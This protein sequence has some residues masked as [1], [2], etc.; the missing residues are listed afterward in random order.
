MSF[1]YQSFKSESSFGCRK[2]PPS[3]NNSLKQQL[4]KD[5]HPNQQSELMELIP[6]G[7]NAG[8]P[9]PRELV[10]L[11]AA[12]SII[13]CTSERAPRID[14]EVDVLVL[15]GGGAGMVAALSAHGQGASVLLATKLRLGDSNT[16][17]ANGISVA[18]GKKD[19]KSLHFLD[20]FIAGGF[21]AD[22]TLVRTLVEE[23]PDAIE[24]LRMQGV[25]LEWNKEASVEENNR[26]AGHSVARGVKSLIGDTGVEIIRT[27]RRELNKHGIKTLQ[28]HPIID[29]LKDAQ[30]RCIGAVLLN[31]DT[32]SYKYVIAK[33][34]ILATGGLGRL[35]CGKS[36]TSNHYGATGDGL[37]VAYRAGAKLV[38]IDSLQY[39]PTGMIWPERCQGRLISEHFRLLG[40]HLVN[41]DGRRFI[42]E[43]ELRD[44]VSAAI[45]RECSEGRGVQAA[46]G[47]SGV[48]LD[49]PELIK[50][51]EVRGIESRTVASTAE[52]L[53][54][55]D[56]DIKKF[57]CLV[58]PTL[59]FH[60]GGLYINS[61]CQTSVPGLFAAGEV[62][63]GIHGNNRLGGN[64]LLEV[65]VF[66]RR[67][68][69]NAANYA[70][71]AC[72]SS[73][74]VDHIIKHNKQS[75]KEKTNS[76]ILFPDYSIDSIGIKQK[77][78]AAN[79]FS[80][81]SS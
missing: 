50:R 8:D 48:W 43:K 51:L 61:Q 57:P 41:R 6:F 33:S 67:A 21:A 29:C 40:A 62:S 10:D 18:L 55:I 17:M 42:N 35:H 2:D 37:V 32:G 59:H 73:V 70:A 26:L 74:N 28:F 1:L 22:P 56:L 34:V 71:N 63:G 76:P 15:G 25:A 46:S 16:L 4:L 79:S 66:G 58:R 49:T 72:R 69:M 64:A 24:W 44:V 39:H 3:L 11:L 45:L 53:M 31:T 23:G 20:T 75:F 77:D 36:I 13:N 65:V 78:T 27:L 30:G 60:N 12:P 7:V 52:R 5:H 9:A 19:S 47:I 54:R 81:E 80:I 38:Q 14:E 68:G